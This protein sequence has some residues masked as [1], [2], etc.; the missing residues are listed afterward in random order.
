MCLVN[1]YMPVVVGQE[2]LDR[3]ADGHKWRNVPIHAVQTLD[4]DEDI[5]CARTD[6]LSLPYK[7]REEPLQGRYIVVGKRA[8]CGGGRGHAG[9][10]EA[11]VHR[12]MDEF[13]VE[14]DVVRAGD[15]REEPD[16]SIVSGRVEQ[17]GG[18]AKERAEALLEQCVLER[19]AVQK[20]AAA[21]AENIRG[22]V[23]AAEEPRAEVWGGSQGEIVVGRKIHRLP[24]L[25][26]SSCFS[27]CPLVCIFGFAWFWEMGKC[28]VTAVTAAT[29]TVATVAVVAATAGGGSRA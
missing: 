8:H 3:L 20:P 23:E 29:A 15:A 28:R 16:V 14:H 25:C 18:R 1:D 13:V 26:V 5:R 4:R 19:G 12:R 7:T 27:C 10:A 11:V 24:R 2:L 17:R 6:V 21:R 22:R 9:Y